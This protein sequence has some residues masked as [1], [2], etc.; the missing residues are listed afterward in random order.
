MTRSNAAERYVV[1]VALLDPLWAGRMAAL[2][3]GGDSSLA[4]CIPVSGIRFFRFRA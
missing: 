2:V 4:H 3:C 1:T